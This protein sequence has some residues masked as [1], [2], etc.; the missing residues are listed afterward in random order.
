MF[1]VKCGHKIADG[2]AFCVNCG[3][4][5]Q[6][7]NNPPLQNKQEEPLAGIYQTLLQNKSGQ[8]QKQNSG[9]SSQ[10]SHRN[11]KLFIIGI[12]IVCAVLIVAVNIISLLP[13]INPGQFFQMFNRSNNSGH[14]I[15]DGTIEQNPIGWTIETIDSPGDVGQHSSLAVD[16]LGHPH[17]SYFDYTNDKIKYATYNGAA[18]SIQSL[19]DASNNNTSIALDSSDQP[20]IGFAQVSKG[21]FYTFFNGSKWVSPVRIPTTDT[22]SRDQIS[23]AINTKNQ[24]LYAS[25]SDFEGQPDVNPYLGYILSFWD[26]SLSGSRVVAYG[27]DQN[28]SYADVTGMRNAVALDSRGNPHIVYDQQVSRGKGSILI[29]D[30]DG[31]KWVKSTIAPFTAMSESEHRFQMSLEY[32][33]KD[34][35]HVVYFNQSAGYQYA[36]RNGNSWTISTINGY[37]SVGWES[38]SMDLDSNDNPHIAALAAGYRL[39]YARYDGSKWI[40]EI[41]DSRSQYVGYDCDLAIGSDDAVHIVYFD[42]ANY[43]LKYAHRLD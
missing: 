33:S 39:L 29:A 8:I 37:G 18:W 1:C 30:W 43:D 25:M 13:K 4:K 10:S 41:I 15:S 27:G 16:R 35:P 9:F 40:S 11:K 36:Y 32:D 21:Y 38:I 34:N 7:Q 19:S 6:N 20:Y 22:N 31:K 42:G 12:L 17:I 5:L 28:S 14:E 2:A 26:S 24:K 3:S 23:I